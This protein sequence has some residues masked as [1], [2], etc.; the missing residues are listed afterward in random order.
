M[1]ICGMRRV[2]AEM[3]KRDHNILAKPEKHHQVGNNGAGTLNE[4][5]Y[6]VTAVLNSLYSIRKPNC[7]HVTSW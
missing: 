1:G 3:T 4:S 5:S 7:G 6:T 2:A